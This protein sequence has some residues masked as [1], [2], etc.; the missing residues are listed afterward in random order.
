MPEKV[1]FFEKANVNGPEAR[2]VFSFL[3]K[4]LPK[5]NGAVDVAWNF[6]TSVLSRRCLAG[7]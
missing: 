6:G 1:V 5:D 2:E 4:A 7:E 3:K